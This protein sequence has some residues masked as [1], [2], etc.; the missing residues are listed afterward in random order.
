MKTTDLKFGDVVLTANMRPIVFLA[1]AIAPPAA[2]GSVPAIPIVGIR[3]GDDDVKT[4]YLPLDV[5]IRG[6]LT[7]A[8]QHADELRGLVRAV[9]AIPSGHRNLVDEAR[10]MLDKIDPPQPVTLDEALGM[11]RDIR[12]V[13]D[14]PGLGVTTG[15]ILDDMLKRA[16]R[17][18][19]LK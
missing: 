3:E 1:R 14:P 12:E 2:P 10:R 15:Q 5:T 18:G 13:I 19:A 8:Q 16:R 17:T 7:P 11:L 9:A 6:E 4:C